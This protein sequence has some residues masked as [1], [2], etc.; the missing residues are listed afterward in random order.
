MAWRQ[1]N[2]P[3]LAR[4]RERRR[5]RDVRGR[6]RARAWSCSTCCTASRRSRP[7]TSRCAGT[8]RPASAARAAWRSTA[9]R[10]SSCM[11]RMNSFAA[12]RDDHGPAAQDVPGDQGPRH[13]RLLELRAEQAHPA[14]QAAAARRRRQATGCTRKTSIACRSSA[15][16][17]SAS[18]ART[19]ATCCATATSKDK[20]VGPRFMIRLAQPRD[21]PARH[22][23]SH[24]GDQATSSARACATSRVLHRGVPRAH[25]HH[26]QRHHPAQGARGRSLLRSRRGILNALGGG[27]KKEPAPALKPDP[28]NG[29]TKNTIPTQPHEGAAREHGRR[30]H[31]G[32]SCSL[33]TSVYRGSGRNT[34]PLAGST[35]RTPS[36]SQ[37]SVCW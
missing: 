10:S 9:S 6:G 19:S 20:F 32:H 7:T 25:R 17:S 34:S 13:R 21:A 12:G 35:R 27:N 16:A 11:T 3:G 36:R 2:L 23:R 24:P 29:S 15:S 1:A 8:A 28:W 5:V 31:R 18:C 30:V 22:R 37:R 4:R 14:V 26:R 33:W